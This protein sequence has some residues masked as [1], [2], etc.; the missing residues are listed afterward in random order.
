MHLLSYI[1][2]V[3]KMDCH[4]FS[5]FLQGLSG[6]ELVALAGLLS[7]VISQN[8]SND[9]VDTLGNFFSALGPNL[10]TIAAAN[11]ANLPDSF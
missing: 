8:L 10:S 3:V 7:V 11:N 9:E 1:V 5:S 6:C 2:L 4:E